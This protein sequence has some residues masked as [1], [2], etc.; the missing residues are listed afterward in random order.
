MEL[1]IIGR[2]LDQVKLNMT[3]QAQSENES[4]ASSDISI[5]DC[6]P[7][8]EVTTP[9][10]IHSSHIRCPP[11]CFSRPILVCTR[12]G[13]MLYIMYACDCNHRICMR[14]Y[15]CANSSLIV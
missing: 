4:P 11:S 2:H 7:L 3:N 9:E 15:A 10:L 14:L 8:S 6:I 1:P 5:P 12:T 13:G